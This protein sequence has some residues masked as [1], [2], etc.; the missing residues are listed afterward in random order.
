MGDFNRDHVLDI[1]TAPAS[2][3]APHLKP[4]IVASQGLGVSTRKDAASA[5]DTAAILRQRLP[6]VFRPARSRPGSAFPHQ[7]RARTRP[8]VMRSST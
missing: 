3:A 7:N 2:G 1:A 5:R 6:V 8:R 4:D